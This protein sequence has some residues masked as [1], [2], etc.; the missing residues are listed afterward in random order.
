MWR[1]PI[2]PFVF[3]SGAAT[4]FLA[5]NAIL[6]IDAPNPPKEGDD[7][8][9][10]ADA[11]QTDG[12]T[13]DST[14][15]CVPSTPL[16]VSTNVTCGAETNVDLLLD[17]N[18][19]G[20]CGRKCSTCNDGLCPAEIVGD[21]TTGGGLAIMLSPADLFVGGA[22]SGDVFRRPRTS[23]TGVSLLT[24]ENGDYAFG[25][26]LDGDRLFV[27][28]YRGIYELSASSDGGGSTKISLIPTEPAALRTGFGQTDTELFWANEQSALDVIQKDGGNRRAVGNADGGT[29]STGLAFDATEVFWIRRNAAS[30]QGHEIRVRSASGSVGV[31][32]SGLEDPRALA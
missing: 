19:C 20:A 10:G 18:N 2:R 24:F 25:L 13:K 15:V 31:R 7:G 30:A 17:P 9:G 11:Q 1:R 27:S 23:G 14:A 4:V 12:T 16:L 5:C 29:L 26:L 21:G 8:D 28:A 22:G 3:A 6:G 32:L